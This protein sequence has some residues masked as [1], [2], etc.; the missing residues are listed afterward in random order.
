MDRTIK[1]TDSLPVRFRKTVEAKD[2]P[3]N[4]DYNEDFSRAYHEA[5]HLY[6][7]LFFDIWFEYVTLIK[8]GNSEAA[9]HHQG[10]EPW[11]DTAYQAVALTGLS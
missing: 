8:D 5:G 3:T 11:T 9:V 4:P 1:N 6:F 10:F 7:H 2:F